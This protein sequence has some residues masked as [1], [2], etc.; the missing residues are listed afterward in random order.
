MNYEEIQ[1]KI[2]YYWEEM[3]LAIMKKDLNRV[4]GCFFAIKNL[5]QKRTIQYN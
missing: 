3:A 2:D 4:R 5:E 1:R